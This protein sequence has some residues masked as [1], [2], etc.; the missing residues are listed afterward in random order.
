M[1]TAQQQ[2]TGRFLKSARILDRSHYKSLYRNSNQLVGQL[3][4]LQFRRAK[5]PCAKL[6]LTVSKKFGKA[7]DRNRFKRLAREAFRSLYRE[8]PLNLEL[9]ITPQQRIS[10]LS[11][12]ALL[13]ELKSMLSKICSPL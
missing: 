2:K 3:F 5:S 8:L 12:Q 13:I 1:D 11:K 4:S 10:E 7:H 6:G 9:N